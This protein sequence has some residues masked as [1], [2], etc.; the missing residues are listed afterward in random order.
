MV[1]LERSI[2]NWNFGKSLIILF[3][4][5]GEQPE[6]SSS[7]TEPGYFCPECRTRLELSG[8]DLLRH[9]R[10]HQQEKQ[11]IATDEN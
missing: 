1:L 3:L 11:N 5:Q 9:Q 7:V 10:K 4:G 8:I 2:L 6:T